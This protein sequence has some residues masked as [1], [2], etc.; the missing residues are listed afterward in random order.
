MTIIILLRLSPCR[1]PD[2]AVRAIGG[3]DNET[4]LKRSYQSGISIP[5]LQFA[6]GADPKMSSRMSMW[7]AHWQ[8]PFRQEYPHLVRQ[9]FPFL[10]RMEAVFND[11]PVPPPPP[12]SRL[13]LLTPLL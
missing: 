2:D 1:L 12:P 13:F 3:W 7:A 9:L 11:D 10:E 8:V 5:G 4:V 6:A